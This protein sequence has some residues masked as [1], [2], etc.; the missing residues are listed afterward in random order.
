M[1]LL[2]QAYAY[3]T[4]KHLP[5][6]FNNAIP[7]IGEEASQNQPRSSPNT[8]QFSLN[9][10]INESQDEAKESTS[11]LQSSSLESSS[12]KQPIQSPS[13]PLLSQTNPIITSTPTNPIFPPVQTLLEDYTHFALPNALSPI[14]TH[15]SGPIRVNHIISRFIPRVA[16]L[17]IPL[18]M[19][20]LTKPPFV[21]GMERSLYRV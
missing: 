10:S 3:Q 16:Q 14:K 7:T 15:I 21:F 19:R 2:K 8:S 18:Y 4:Q 13:Q 9:Q 5:A 1:N 20:F 11:N 12:P 6:N 17:L